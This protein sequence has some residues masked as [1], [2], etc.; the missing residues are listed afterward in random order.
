MQ[1]DGDGSVAIESAA[2][3][4][5]EI[6][7]GAVATAEILDDTILPEDVDLTATYSWTGAHTHLAA[8][9]VGVNDTGH[10]VKFFGATA[11]SSFLWDESDDELVLTAATLQ[12]GGKV[13]FALNGGAASASGL[14]MGVGTT[15]SPA[16][17]AVVDAFFAEFRT[18]SSA[19]T[20]TSRGL[21]WRHELTGAGGG[22][23]IRAFTKLSAAAGTARGAH[24][25]LDVNTSGSITG[26]GVGVDAQILVSNQALGGGTYGVV[27]AEIYSAGSSSS[28]AASNIAFFRAVAGGDGTGAATVDTGGDLMSINGLSVGS[29]KLFQVNTAADATHALRISIDGVPYYIMLTNSGA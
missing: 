5:A 29:G 19:A 2:V 24:V 23:C 9:T 26:L 14:L 18:Q 20:G 3:T 21:Y 1:V 11:G 27:N 7:T 28:V 15:G 25:S 17:T 10:D 8:V 16:T 6:A 22:E 12:L 4:A 13:K